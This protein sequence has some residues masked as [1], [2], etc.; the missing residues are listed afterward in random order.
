MGGN[1]VATGFETMLLRSIE[2]GV[3]P[4]RAVVDQRDDVLR[5]VVSV[6]VFAVEPAAAAA[7][8]TLLISICTVWC[9]PKDWSTAWTRVCC[10]P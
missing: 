2:M 8:L 9:G 1:D 6:S 4:G 5:V 3:V 7:V 10:C